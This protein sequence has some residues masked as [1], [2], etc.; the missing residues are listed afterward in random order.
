MLIMT[1]QVVA[2]FER[3]IEH[4]FEKNK[5]RTLLCYNT[6]Q[7][8]YSFTRKITK[9]FYYIYVYHGWNKIKRF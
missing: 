3:I 4:L 9:L 5:K 7:N 8:P 1:E 6:R 2:Q